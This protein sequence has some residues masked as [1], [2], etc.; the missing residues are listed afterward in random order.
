MLASRLHKLMRL[1][2]AA[3]VDW[4]VLVPGPN[5]TYVSGL[6]LFVSE[7]PIVAFFPQDERKRPAILIPELEKGRAA[8]AVAGQA[9]FYPYTDQGGYATAFVQAAEALALDGKRVAVEYRQMRVLELRQLEAAA[10]HAD[11]VAL[12]ETL[13][14]LRIHKDQDE[15]NALRAAIEIT[16]TALHKLV[17]RPLIGLT[18]REI[19]ARLAQNMVDAGAE[20]VAF[21]IVV[22]GP[23]SADPHAGPSDRPVQAGDLV[24][25]DCGA[26]SGGYP[27]DITRTFAMGEITP[28]LKQVYQTVLRA[29]E[30]GK[31]AAKPG[32]PAQAVDHAARQVIDEAGY[33]D[34]FIHR[35]GHGLG[36]EV[37]EPPYIVQGNEQRLEPGMVFTVEPGIYLPGVGGVR[38]ED[39]VLITPDGA[40]CL[41]TLARELQAVT[42]RS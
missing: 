23:N 10:P 31:A 18:E 3:G 30:A 28:E 1:E 39:D 40:E 38:I 13:P 27:A 25:I 34:Y 11:F 24:T 8:R 22:A 29:N 14:D 35:T 2:R 33:G 9:D 12:E 4:V 26:V 15:I 21:I 19:A 7:R 16:E 32:A 41:T 36:I 17:S 5:L 20:R 42:V 6:T 37:H